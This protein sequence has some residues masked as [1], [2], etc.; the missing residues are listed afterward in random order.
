MDLVK[1]VVRV[2]GDVEVEG[3]VCDFPVVDL[4]G[5][6]V[7]GRGDGWVDGGDVVGIERPVF[8]GLIGEGEVIISRRGDGV[9]VVV[10]V[11]YRCSAGFDFGYVDGA[12]TS[13]DVGSAEHQWIHDENRCRLKYVYGMPN[14]VEKGPSYMILIRAGT[15]CREE[16]AGAIDRMSWIV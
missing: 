3:R 14:R 16:Y 5:S 12:G 7:A 10:G 9:E 11:G 15:S 6:A 8:G 2:H 4:V 13:K 1:L